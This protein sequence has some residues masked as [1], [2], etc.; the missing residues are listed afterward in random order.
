MHDMIYGTREM[1]FRTPAALGCDIPTFRAILNLR[2]LCIWGQEVVEKL[3]SRKA[4][5]K[6]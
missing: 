3:K 2:P 5:D 1:W 6:K 4:R